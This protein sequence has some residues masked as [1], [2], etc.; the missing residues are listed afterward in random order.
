MYKNQS[1]TDPYVFIGK[2][3]IVLVYVDDFL[4]FS[5]KLSG[6]SDRLIKPLKE[7]NENFEFTDEGD[8]KRCLWVDITKHKDGRIEV[9]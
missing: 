5:K 1:T 2:L 9:T 3:S 8:L 4:I 7:G 6:V